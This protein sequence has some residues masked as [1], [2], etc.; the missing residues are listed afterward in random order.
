M[1]N[2]SKRFS[3]LSRLRSF[4]YAFRGIGFAF[5]QEHNLWIHTLA[6]AAAIIMGFLLHISALEWI[7]IAIVIA[8]VFV[9]ELFNSA[10]ESLVDLCSPDFNEK[11]GRI[12]D[13]AAGAVLIAALGA[14]TAGLIIFIPKIVGACRL[15][16]LFGFRK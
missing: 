6:A 7:V 3:L 16:F 8:G 9:S 4:Y 13:M 15:I 1:K 12:K 11:A 2:R 10:I 14:L 5:R